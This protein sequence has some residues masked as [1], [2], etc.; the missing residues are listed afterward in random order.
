M[1]HPSF[2]DYACDACGKPYCERINIMNLA[3]DFVEDQYCL[4][5]LAKEYEKSEKEMATFVWGYVSARECFL[6]PW[7]KFEPSSC[8]KLETNTCYCQGEHLT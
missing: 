6:T 8:P 3:L 1:S 2:F 7:N 4:D 5:C